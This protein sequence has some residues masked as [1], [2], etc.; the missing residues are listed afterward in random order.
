MARVGSTS[1]V[2]G[3][4]PAPGQA[5]VNLDPRMPKRKKRVGASKPMK[6][7]GTT[8]KPRVGSSN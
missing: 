6:R 1:R 8:K 3:T 5:S 7:V 4:T 2:G